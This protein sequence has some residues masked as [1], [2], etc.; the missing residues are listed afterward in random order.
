MSFLRSLNISGSALTAMKFRMS[1][2]AQNLANSSSAAGTQPYK[3][4]AVQMTERKDDAAFQK[5]LSDAV[6]EIN[7]FGGVMVSGVTE[8]ESYILEFDPEN[9]LADENGYVRLPNIDTTEQMI[10]LMA[11]SRAYEANVTA[12]NAVKQMAQKALEIGR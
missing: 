2:A 8:E 1:V 12:F 3:K 5:R 7:S 4:K 6:N 10:E 11:A 9:P